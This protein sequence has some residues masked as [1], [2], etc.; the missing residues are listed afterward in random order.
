[1]KKVNIADFLLFLRRPTVQEQTNINSFSSFLRLIWEIFLIILFVDFAYS[2]IIIIPLE[3]FNL[4]PI[5]LDPKF[6]V[7][8][9]LKVTLLLPMTEEIIFRLPLQISKVNLITSFC[10]LVLVV[11]HRYCFSN[12]Y[13]PIICSLIV[14]LLL[15]LIIRLKPEFLAGLICYLRDHF[16]KFFYILTIVFGLLHLTDYL[17]SFKFIFLF[18]LYIISYVIVGSL[19]GYIRI[20]YKN[21]FYLCTTAHILVNCVYA[22]LIFN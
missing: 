16:W 2:V 4:F 11:L 17:V 18:P 7:I 20:K 14:F 6:T 13:L 21:G 9:V 3:H 5:R 12:F 1:L 8:N 19:L 10:L 15:V 22:I